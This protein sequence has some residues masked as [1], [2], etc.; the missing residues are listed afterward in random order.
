MGPDHDPFLG[1]RCV[2][3]GG[4]LLASCLQVGRPTS[5]ETDCEAAAVL[6]VVFIPVVPGSVRRDCESW[7]VAEWEQKGFGGY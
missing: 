6:H 7:A 3:K 1:T 2:E 5:K 4:S